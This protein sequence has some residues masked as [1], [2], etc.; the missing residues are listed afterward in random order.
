[1]YRTTSFVI[2]LLVLPSAAGAGIAPTKLASGPGGWGLALREDGGFVLSTSQETGSKGPVARVQMH[3]PDGAVEW[4]RDFTPY[5]TS[6]SVAFAADGSIL[7]G[8]TILQ[9]DSSRPCPDARC[10]VAR[11]EPDGSLRWSIMTPGAATSIPRVLDI[12]P[13]ADGH[14]LIMTM[15]YGERATVAK[16]DGATGQLLW[17]T[18]LHATA[19]GRALAPT[20]DGGAYATG[21]FGTV[22]LSATGALVW[23]RAEIGADVLA[24]GSDAL[25]ITSGGLGR[26]AAADGAVLWHE[27]SVKSASNFNAGLA[28]RG[29]DVVVVT[30]Q[31]TRISTYPVGRVDTQYLYGARVEARSLSDGAFGWGFDHE[32]GR[33]TGGLMTER[34]FAAASDG[35]VALVA[36]HWDS[37][38]YG[39]GEPTCVEDADELCV[40]V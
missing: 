36:G 3:A 33:T 6:A 13:S 31:H 35:R 39:L 5:S 1:M 28:L 38:V 27:P 11:L 10:E 17:R 15:Q 24:V 21:D 26:Y 37:A 30:P 14:V 18:V 22:R 29:D 34:V 7:V 12:A 23:S 32:S 16:L 40:Y 25:V 20:P 19:F 2:L 4:T 8:T 9:F